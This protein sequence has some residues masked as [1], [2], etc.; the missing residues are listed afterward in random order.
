MR[1]ATRLLLSALAFVLVA[2]SA[3]AQNN[4]TFQVNMQPYITTCQHV[5]ATDR[6]EVRGN[7]F[8]WDDTAPDMTDNG[9]GTY[10]YTASLAEGTAVSFKFWSSG[11][12]EYEDGTG[13]RAYTVT[14]EANQTVGL[15]DFADGAPVDECGGPVGVPTDYSFTFAVDMS[16]QIGRGAFDPATQTVAVAGSFTDWGTSP[17]D[18]A[19]DSGTSGLYA[20]VIDATVDAPGNAQFKFVIRNADG[21]INAWENVDPNVTN[22]V[23]G[24]NRVFRLTGNETD[25]DGDGDLDLFYDNNDDTTNLPFFSDQDAS[26]FLTGPATVTFNVDARSAQYALAATG[27]LPSG[28]TTFTSLAINGP[29]AGESEQDGGPS[30]GIGDWAG[31]GAVLA[32]I[33][34][35]QLTNNGDNQWSIT[36]T[37]AAGAARNLV[38][39]FGANGGDNESGFG[40]DHQFSISEGTTTINLAFGCVR[41]N[42]P[43]EGATRFGYVDETGDGA[44]VA[45]DEY[46]LIRNDL[47][48]ATC[49][50]VPSGGVAGDVMTVA[51]ESGPAIAGLTIGTVAPNPAT[52]RAS[53][54]LTLDRAMSV[55]ARL[56]DVT[57]R[58]VATLVEG[59]LSAGR[60]PVSVDASGL[61]AGVYVLRVAADGQVVSRRLTVV[62]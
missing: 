1:S 19:E 29:A 47:D 6:V 35:R 28:E 57:G 53:V 22:E 7:V 16:V 39:K 12:L 45:Y 2:G 13:D 3:G 38:A 26:Q 9:D 44:F 50:T 36:L 4:V 59:S 46:L 23:E 60:T 62:R 21:T 37:Y 48:P 27:S 51:G 10:S 31:W 61:S 24:G 14:G 49:V 18:L 15:I 11:G 42:V 25:T 5:P 33:P 54:E 20:G 52:G 55:S 41:R 32:G 43:F 34:E 30:G 40:G 58:E 8:G 56:Y 17:I